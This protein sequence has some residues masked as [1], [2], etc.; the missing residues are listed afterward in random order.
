MSE[1]NT[2]VAGLRA[3]GVRYLSGGSDAADCADARRPDPAQLLSGL[4]RSTEPRLRH[5]A[6]ALFLV[7]PELAE[8]APGAAA[9]LDTHCRAALVEAYVAAVYLQRLWRSRL[10]RHLGEQPLLPPLWIDELGLPA[11]DD[12]YGK[13]GL[14]AL[15]ARARRGGGPGA[16]MGPYFVVA[17]H[18]FGQLLGERAA[19]AA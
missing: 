16:A 18:L 12:R 17:Q 13:L 6:A 9:A 7:H 3:Y 8:A 5:A 1:W 11:P 4:A 14:A 10:R 15:T 19:A 2:L